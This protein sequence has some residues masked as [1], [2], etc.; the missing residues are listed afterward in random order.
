[1]YS[2]QRI[3]A[4]FPSDRLKFEEDKIMSITRGRGWAQNDKNPLPRPGRP[5]SSET[6]DTANLINIISAVDNKNLEDRV[7]DVVK[8]ISDKGND[9]ILK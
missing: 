3:I 9:E 4:N 5:L 6:I 1:M 7:K 2:I 8:Y